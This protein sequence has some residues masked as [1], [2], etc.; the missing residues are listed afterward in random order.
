MNQGDFMKQVFIFSIILCGLLVGCNNN[1]YNPPVDNNSFD[2]K[3]S[4]TR[5][6]MEGY[7]DKDSDTAARAIMKFNEAQKNRR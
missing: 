2:Y 6:K 3:Y 4:K 1:T 7:S 5:F